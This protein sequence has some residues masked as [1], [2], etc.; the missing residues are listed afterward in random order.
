MY[1]QN[2]NNNKK[3]NIFFF[4]VYKNEWKEHKF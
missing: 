1:T 3:N 4:T 2:H